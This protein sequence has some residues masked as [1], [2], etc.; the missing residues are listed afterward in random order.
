VSSS[1]KRRSP[2]DD[3]PTIE[4]APEEPTLEARVPAPT[5]E[6]AE[7]PTVSAQVDVRAAFAEE[8]SKML[9]FAA[10]VAALEHPAHREERTL[11]LPQQQQQQ[12]RA[13]APAPVAVA[14]GAG[15]PPTVPVRTAPVIDDAP[16]DL[17]G[18]DPS[19]RSMKGVVFGIL[20]VCAL[21]CAGAAFISL[22]PHGKAADAAPS[23]TE[24]QATTATATPSATA[25]S[26]A[27][28]PAEVAT[29][30]AAPTAT[31]ATITPVA[32]EPRSPAPARAPRVSSG[33]GA[34]R[35]PEPRPPA[36]PAKPTSKPPIVR[37]APF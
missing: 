1:R 2:Y 34:A 5:I 31:T 24:A 22:W 20:G 3:E 26:S 18:L 8:Q 23:T 14:V 7:D 28:Q 15:P 4:A 21:L 27:S 36:G 35:R 33:A 17:P 9:P 10:T 16:V 30:T 19:R 11:P 37:D 32:T 29:P 25:S 6:V 13:S 12:Q